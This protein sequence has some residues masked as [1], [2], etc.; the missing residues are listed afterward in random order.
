MIGKIKYNDNFI[1]FSLLKIQ[2]FLDIYITNVDK[3]IE[4]KKIFQINLGDM[5]KKNH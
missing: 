1:V 5:L 2:N 4:C 3:L